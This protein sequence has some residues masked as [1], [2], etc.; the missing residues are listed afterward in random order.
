MMPSPRTPLPE[1]CSATSTITPRLRAKEKSTTTTAATYHENDTPRT[2]GF[3]PQRDPNHTLTPHSERHP[4]SQCS[5]PPHKLHRFFSP[6]HL[7]N[8]SDEPLQLETLTSSTSSS[9]QHAKAPK[10]PHQ[11]QEPI[12]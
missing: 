2:A 12:D 3:Q 4:T 6:P 8:T 1:L 7:T 11:N 5:N 9:T 10:I